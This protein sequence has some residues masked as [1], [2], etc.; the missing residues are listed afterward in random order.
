MFPFGSTIVRPDEFFDQTGSGLVGRDTVVVKLRKD[1]NKNHYGEL[2]ITRGI[3]ILGV[4]LIHTSS[5][6]LS[7]FYYHN[8]T[9]IKILAHYSVPLFL[10]I[11]GFLYKSRPG[12]EAVY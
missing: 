4:V 6:Y 7:N 11:S 3:A 12:F 10:L 5:L 1:M 8:L 2:D 9:S